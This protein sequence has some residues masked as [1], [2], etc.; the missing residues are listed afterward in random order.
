M[1]ETDN[2][3]VITDLDEGAVA[4]LGAPRSVVLASSLG[5]WL[6]SNQ[7]LHCFNGQMIPVAVERTRL[8]GR[9]L[10]LIRDIRTQLAN[11]HA[12]RRIEASLRHI[13]ERAPQAILVHRNGRLLMANPAAHA[14]IR[15][16]KSLVD[17][18]LLTLFLPLQG[19]EQAN[20]S[21]IH[22]VDRRIRRFDG[23]V[24]DVEVTTTPIVF[25]GEPAMGS[26]LHDQTTARTLQKRMLSMDRVIT[27]GTLATSVAHE[28]KNP[29]TF[30]ATN[31]AYLNEV[32]NCADLQEVI[33][34]CMTGIDHLRT[35]IGDLHGLAQPTAANTLE[36]VDV[37][38]TLDFALRM[39]G[40]YLYDRAKI[41][42]TAHATHSVRAQGTRLA[43]V[44]VNLLINAGQAIGEDPKREHT[45]QIASEDAGRY[46]EIRICDDGPGITPE[47]LM[48]VFEP[49][50]TTKNLNQGIGLGLT[51]C[52]QL[53]EECGGMLT[54]ESQL[55]AGTTC[56]VRLPK[57]RQPMRRLTQQD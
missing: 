53:I 51:I 2:R 6:S 23:E 22:R 35:I 47:E 49:F 38:S 42:R 48:H 8:H 50:F 30:L 41:T 27:V 46:V 29:I 31:L 14:M 43:Q 40:P 5:V 39:A 9:T 16:T 21:T 18:P 34:E 20:A 44:F 19:S 55:G 4:L 32:V 57:A 37:E 17:H 15:A 26:F 1:I 12:Q 54:L 7:H 25:D 10:L 3:G 13:I 11:H 56:I 52:R 28:I 33:H 24:I 45:V 36:S